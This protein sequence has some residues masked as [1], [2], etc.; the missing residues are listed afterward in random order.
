MFCPGS[1][2]MGILGLR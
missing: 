1:V 2:H